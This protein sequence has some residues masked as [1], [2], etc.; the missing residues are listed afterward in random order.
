MPEINYGM[1]LVHANRRCYILASKVSGE[2]KMLTIWAGEKAEINCASE[3]ISTGRL[4]NQAGEMHCNF[5]RITG[6]NGQK[7]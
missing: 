7:C 1:C 6:A 4:C 5:H 2:E 3:A